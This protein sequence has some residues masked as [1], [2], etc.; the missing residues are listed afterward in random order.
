MRYAELVRHLKISG[1]IT[2]NLYCADLLSLHFTP[3]V[4]TKQGVKMFLVQYPSLLA[5]NTFVG[6]VMFSI[7]VMNEINEWITGLETLIDRRFKDQE[8]RFHLAYEALKAKRKVKDTKAD[9]L[10]SNDYV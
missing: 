4:H 2:A 7:S 6:N 1:E 9:I 5:I 3:L 8:A 10:L